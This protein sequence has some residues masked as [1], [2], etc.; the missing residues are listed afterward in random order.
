MNKPFFIV[1][2]FNL[3]VIGVSK[4]VLGN[5]KNIEIKDV[6]GD[7][8]KELVKGEN[9]EEESKKKKKVVIIKY[10]TEESKSKS[11]K[12]PGLGYIASGWTMVGLSRAATTVLGTFFVLVSLI[13]CADC[14]ERF[15]E[16]NED[17]RM[18]GFLLPLFGPVTLSGWAI[19]GLLNGWFEEDEG[20]VF[21]ML[22]LGSTLW[23]GFEVAGLYL[24][25]Y[26]HIIRSRGK[27]K[28][29]EEKEKSYFELMKRLF[30]MPQVYKDYGI[31]SLVTYF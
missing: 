10:V 7:K 23:T 22:L 4:I 28:R 18:I 5:E 15:V 27:P 26:G 25:T 6:D 8:E 31:I 17:E 20:A 16:E 19:A 2:L 12:R 30:V 13:G 14:G 11:E 21:S 1:I 9:K 24:A 3:W 29:K